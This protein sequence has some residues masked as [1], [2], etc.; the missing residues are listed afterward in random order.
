MSPGRNPIDSPASIAGLDNT[1]RPTRPA[2]SAS[3]AL[4]M[5]R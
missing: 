4:A 5:A 2:S 1:I 3:T